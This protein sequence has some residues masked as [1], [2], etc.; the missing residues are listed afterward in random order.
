MQRRVLL[1]LA[2]IALT[3]SG[4]SSA[5][6]RAPHLI[7]AQRGGA[8]QGGPGPGTGKENCNAGQVGEEDEAGWGGCL[9]CV[10]G[11]N[12][13]RILQLFRWEASSSTL[14]SE[15]NLTTAG[16]RESRWARLRHS[17]TNLR[18]RFRQ[19]DQSPWERIHGRG[20]GKVLIRN[21]ATEMP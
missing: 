1:V 9:P 13:S 18:Q 3:N 17:A 12:T 20:A 5:L 8:P 16:T 4:T 21:R 19:D 7:P 10:P 14:T 2:T 11:L 15:V 6:W